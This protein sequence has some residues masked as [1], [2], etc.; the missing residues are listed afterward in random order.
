MKKTKQVKKKIRLKNITK[1]LKKSNKTKKNRRNKT[2]NNSL[3]KGGS[4]K[5]PIKDAFDFDRT[6]EQ[7][8]ARDRFFKKMTYNNEEYQ[9]I[10]INLVNSLK[11]RLN[12]M[13]KN[14]KPE[15][16]AIVKQILTK[17]IIFF[18]DPDVISSSFL[19]AMLVDAEPKYKLVVYKSS[20]DNSFFPY[21]EEFI[22]PDIK[23]YLNFNLLLTNSYLSAIYYNIDDQ[24]ICIYLTYILYKTI[25][26]VLPPESVALVTDF[27][28]FNLTTPIQ[29]AIETNKLRLVG[30]LMYIIDRNRPDFQLDYYAPTDYYPSI[31]EG[32]TLYGSIQHNFLLR[33]DLIKSICMDIYKDKSYKEEFCKKY[34]MHVTK[35]YMDTVDA[36]INYTNSQINEKI[37]KN[38]IV[39][40]YLKNYGDYVDALDRKIKP[41]DKKEFWEFYYRAFGDIYERDPDLRNIEILTS[42]QP[43]DDTDLINAFDTSPVLVPTKVKQPPAKNKGAKKGSIKKIETVQSI[44]KAPEEVISD[45]KKETT[46]DLPQIEETSEKEAPELQIKE[47]I[48]MPPPEEMSEPPTPPEINIAFYSNEELKILK[49]IINSLMVESL[50]NETS[51]SICDKIKS[52]VV[53]YSIKQTPTI[54]NSKLT[55]TQ[56]ELKEYNVMSCAIFII[57]GLISHKLNERGDY[58]LIIK[59]GKGLQLS[60]VYYLKYN[61]E[62]EDIDALLVNKRNIDDYD[63]KLKIAVYI[64]ELIKWII[65]TPEFKNIGFLNPTENRTN[66][67][68]GKISYVN[69]IKKLAILDIDIKF[70]VDNIQEK[71]SV[72]DFDYT[73]LNKVGFP[74]GINFYN[75][76][77]G[78]IYDKTFPVQ[79]LIVSFFYQR[80]EVALREKIYLYTKYFLLIEIIKKLRYSSTPENII[81]ADTDIKEY[82]RFLQKFKRSIK[83]IFYYLYERNA[84]AATDSPYK[85]L[86]KNK[87]KLTQI[88]SLETKPNLTQEERTKVG[89]KDIVETDVKRYEEQ[90]NK[91]FKEYAHSEYFSNLIYSGPENEAIFDSIIN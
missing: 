68:V 30:V 73:E 40:I 2:K 57:I 85:Q 1:K 19:L 80:I 50:P 3:K 29:V 32:S 7:D 38:R 25:L 39:P 13:K 14:P 31:R 72:G 59:G 10:F 28:L 33:A 45:V 47:E 90:N 22:D 81:M 84:T 69:G 55:L 12:E 23:P 4:G 18:S 15:E 43:Q 21:S 53:N 62:S 77:E 82:T 52:S 58:Q 87:K 54:S 6:P 37:K 8:D 20:L 17:F 44:I 42:T 49:N 16:D 63:N 9:F 46:E 36:L 35:D 71:L 91:A 70:P 66:K 67:N 26:K 83:A 56:E 24:N 75:F 74:L 51:V 11:K 64:G 65:G 41:T 89:T 34:V 76:E 48:N 88:I 60:F 27:T 5:G 79:G 61:F 86:Q 78:Q